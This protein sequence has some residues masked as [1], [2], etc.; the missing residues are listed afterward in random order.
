MVRIGLVPRFL[1]FVRDGAWEGVHV[2]AAYV[3]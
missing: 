1:S 3:M 2:G